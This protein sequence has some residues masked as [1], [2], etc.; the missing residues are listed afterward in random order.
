V[1]G[2][3]GEDIREEGIPFGM[4]EMTGSESATAEGCNAGGVLLGGIGNI[5]QGRREEQLEMRGR[6]A[7]PEQL[8]DDDTVDGFGVDK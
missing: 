5:S 4:G 6:A 2:K 8:A 7:Q 1:G 3:G